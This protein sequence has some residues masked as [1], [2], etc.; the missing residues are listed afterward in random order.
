MSSKLALIDKYSP[1][2]YTSSKQL[3]ELMSKH[4]QRVQDGDYEAEYFSISGISAR[5][6]DMIEK[7]R[8]DL[9]AAVRFT[10]FGDIDTLIIKVVTKLH[11]KGHLNLGARVICQSGL[12]GLSIS[13]CQ[14][15][16]ATKYTGQNESSKEGDSSFINEVIRPNDGDW[17]SLVIESGYSESMPR[18]QND[19]RWWIGESKGEVRIVLLVQLSP[20]SRRIIIEKWTPRAHPR[21]DEGAKV[22]TIQIDSATTPVVTG[23]LLVLEFDQV[24]LRSANPPVEHD[25]RLSQ[26]DLS[27]YA[28]NVWSGL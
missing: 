12:M 20:I 28:S 16:G 1:S 22:A 15:L 10:Y 8:R 7:Q 11:E 26:R 17:P 4:Y 21:Q 27:E 3:R 23:A 6:F 24:F 25:I 19:M 14:P 2:T 13:E 9:G 5:V 18:L